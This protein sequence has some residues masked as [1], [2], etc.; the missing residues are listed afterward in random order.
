MFKNEK[1]LL[2]NIGVFLK[3]KYI[4]I[5]WIDS[6]Y[7]ESQV[8]IRSSSIKA[9]LKSINYLLNGMFPKNYEQNTYNPIP[10]ETVPSSFDY[11]T[12]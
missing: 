12:L 3:Q 9:C 1:Y 2:K 11:V 7:D 8:Y 6:V 5:N 4:D 10:I